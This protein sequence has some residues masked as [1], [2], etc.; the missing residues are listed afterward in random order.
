MQPSLRALMLRASGSR[1]DLPQLHCNGRFIGSLDE[2]QQLEDE[3][4]LDQVPLK[5]P[6][7]QRNASG[8]WACGSSGCGCARCSQGLSTAP[9]P[10]PSL[11]LPNPTFPSHSCYMS[12][13]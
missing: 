2:I 8:V 10:A 1:P 6:R 9:T 7:Q 5:Y 11:P 4:M 13:A 12:C 3:G